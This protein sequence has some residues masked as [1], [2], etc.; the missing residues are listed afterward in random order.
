M[1]RSAGPYIPATGVA[2]YATEAGQRAVQYAFAELDLTEVCSVILPE[3]ARSIA[4]A[5]RLGFSLDEERVISHFPSMPHGIWR[6]SRTDWRGA[7]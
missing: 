2:G 4:V 3:N 7:S 1:S 5:R 6:L